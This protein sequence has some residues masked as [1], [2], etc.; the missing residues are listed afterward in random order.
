MIAKSIDV[1]N[2]LIMAAANAR[3]MYKL[4]QDKKGGRPNKSH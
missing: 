2:D 4:S 1:K 3:K